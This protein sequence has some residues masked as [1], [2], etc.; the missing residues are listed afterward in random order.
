M[1]H[2]AAAPAATAAATVVRH[3]VTFLGTNLKTNL[4]LAQSVSAAASAAAAMIQ[5]VAGP[6]SVLS[7]PP[8]SLVTTDQ[9]SQGRGHE[10]ENFRYGDTLEMILT[11]ASRSTVWALPEGKRRSGT[12]VQFLLEHDRLQR[13]HFATEDEIPLPGN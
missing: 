11:T 1:L 4:Y 12:G 8:L 7:E 6:S 5:P 2:S 9:V 10:T 3:K 13:A